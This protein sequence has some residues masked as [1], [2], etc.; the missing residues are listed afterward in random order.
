MEEMVEEKRIQL[1]PMDN[2]RLFAE[3]VEEALD[4]DELFR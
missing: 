3:I 4:R 2:G 1:R